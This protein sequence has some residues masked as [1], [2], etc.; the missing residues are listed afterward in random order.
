MPTKTFI[1]LLSTG[2]N[3]NR[4]EKYKICVKPNRNWSWSSCNIIFVI[5]HEY[6][7]CGA[8]VS[9]GMIIYDIENE[10]TI[11]IDDRFSYDCVPYL[12]N[13]LFY[14]FLDSKILLI[15]GD[16]VDEIPNHHGIV[17]YNYGLNLFVSDN[18]EIG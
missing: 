3:M 18:F 6:N 12:I 10:Y 5:I 2:L 1:G 14:I 15:D 16:R 4:F 9:T 13:G 11:N 17:Y 7:Q 8:S